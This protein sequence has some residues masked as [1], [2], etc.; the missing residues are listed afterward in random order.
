[1][2]AF[3]ITIKGY[4]PSEAG[5]AKCIQSSWDVGNEFT[6][7]AHSATTPLNV[8]DKLEEFELDWNWPWE[9]QV[10]DMASGMTKKAYPTVDKAKR[11]SCSLSHFELWALSHDLNEDILVLEHDALFTKK[12]PSDIM[13]VSRFDVLGINNPLGATR[14]SKLFHDTIQSNSNAQQS[15]PHIDAHNIPQGI[16]GNS[17]YIVTPEGAEQLIKLSYQYGLWPNDAI[18]C[19]QLVKNLGVTKTYYTALQNIRS[20]TTL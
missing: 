1:M 7:Q 12:L 19:R 10:I 8:Q 5:A 4:S 11:V 20:T 15:V 13:D 18:M 3:I 2:R 9:G 17:A 14:K 6:I 16:A